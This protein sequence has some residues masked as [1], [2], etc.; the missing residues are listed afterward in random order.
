MYTPPHAVETTQWIIAIGSVGSALVALALG[1]GLR[2]WVAR[3]RVRLVLR[4]ADDPEEISD[5]VVTKRLVSGETAAFVRLRLDNRGR[6]TARNVAVRVLKV[7]RWD[8]ASG[9]WLRSRPELDGRLLQ[10]SNQLESEPDLVDVF[11]YSDRI[12]DLASVDHDR[13]AQGAS[14]IFVEI[15]RPWPPN[16]ANVLEPGTWR[17]ELLVCGDNITPERSFVTLSF[18]GAWPQPESSAIWEHFVVGG[19]AP[20]ISSPTQDATALRRTSAI[21]GSSR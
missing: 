3:P 13:A 1:L 10:P 16:E 21:E 6:S 20:E 12:V 18:D 11:P 7:H 15:S 9:D 17:L 14:P 19:P 8:P 2:D 4:H 5:R